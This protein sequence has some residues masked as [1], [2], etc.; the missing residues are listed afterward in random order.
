MHP[1]ESNTLSRY[2]ALEGALA[3]FDG[4]EEDDPLTAHMLSRMDGLWHQLTN[5][6]RE[7]LNNRPPPTLTVE[8]D[9]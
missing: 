9:P 7:Y 4:D 2:L 1:S 3:L 6:E 5:D 8:T